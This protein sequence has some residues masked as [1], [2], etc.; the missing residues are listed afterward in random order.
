MR[1]TDTLKKLFLYGGQ[2]GNVCGRGQQDQA[3][4][5]AV[6]VYFETWVDDANDVQ[7]ALKRFFKVSNPLLRER[8]A[9]AEL[10]L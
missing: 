4:A 8:R 10:V 9:R 2:L 3:A 6:L 5:F 7:V 1:D